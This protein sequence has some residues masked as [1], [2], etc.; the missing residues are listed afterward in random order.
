MLH[1]DEPAAGP[2]GKLGLAPAEAK[3]GWTALDP[4]D[5]QPFDQPGG[6]RAIVDAA[7]GQPSRGRR[8]K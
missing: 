4:A 7:A 8:G 2:R 1:K 3:T 5:F 6:V